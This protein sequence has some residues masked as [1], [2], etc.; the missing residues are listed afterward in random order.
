MPAYKSYPKTST[1]AFTIGKGFQSQ[2]LAKFNERRKTGECC[3]L[4]LKVD[5]KVL[6][7]HKAV[8]I[9]RSEYF[10]RMLTTGFKETGSTEIDYSGT[11]SDLNVLNQVV[12]FIYTGKIVINEN[13]IE[14]ILQAS[15]LFLIDDLKNIC[16]EYLLS[17]LSLDNCCYTLYLADMF[18]FEK[19]VKLC[20]LM[21]SAHFGAVSYTHL[22]LPTKA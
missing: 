16:A 5:G 1:L 7:A 13:D 21:I 18:N 2:I 12:S 11:F 15:S 3:D 14:D 22:T 17:N 6:F 4:K 19:L 10:N 8:L 20:E 9:E